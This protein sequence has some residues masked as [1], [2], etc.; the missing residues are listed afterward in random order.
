M[1]IQTATF[2][3]MPR[4]YRLWEEAFDAKTDFLNLFF[5]KGI[6]LSQTYVCKAEGQIVSALSVFK[7]NHSGHKGAYIYG[8]CTDQNFRKKSYAAN[9]LKRV[10]AI[11]TD[12]G[13]EFFIIRPATAELA[14]YYK[15]LGYTNETHINK[16]KLPLP[17]MA[18]FIPIKELT[19]EKLY[20]LRK[21]RFGDN[22]VEWD[23]K[24]L[25]FMIEFVKNLSGDAIVFNDNSYLIGYPEGNQY[26]ILETT[27]T[28]RTLS[29]HYIKNTYPE[30][31]SAVITELPC[32]TSKSIEPF[33]LYKSTTFPL[34]KDL[35]F[36]L[37]ME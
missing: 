18:N 20:S 12:K 10:E 35:Y 37:T 7:V 13:Y 1:N 31:N 5:S 25:A 11:L 19:A 16:E 9:L 26:I 2:E 28:K 27:D 3:D 23:S 32:S 22:L 14:E 4:L 17:S 30:L 6:F 24:S 33:I 15:K 36:N 29:L 21:E 8:I 34:T